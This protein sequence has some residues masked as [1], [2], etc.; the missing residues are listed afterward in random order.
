MIRFNIVILVSLV[1]W[2]RTQAQ[3]IENCTTLK[4]DTSK[5]AEI[6]IK[7]LKAHNGAWKYK[8]VPLEICSLGGGFIIHFGISEFYRK[9]GFQLDCD[10]VGKDKPFNNKVNGLKH[11]VWFEY[12]LL[13]R[14]KRAAEYDSGGVVGNVITF[15]P[16][17]YPKHI[18]RFNPAGRLVQ[19]SSESYKRAL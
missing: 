16:D 13:G 9:A 5:C 1:L 8:N 6:V 17:G 3:G 12:D 14:V 19:G 2:G 10:K 7:A 15:W 18:E 11:G 4:S